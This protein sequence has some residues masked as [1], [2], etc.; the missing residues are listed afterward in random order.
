ME[1]YTERVSTMLCQLT[2]TSALNTLIER[3]DI[4]GGRA[5]ALNIR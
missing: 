3:N 1:R 5:L 2:N 4:Y